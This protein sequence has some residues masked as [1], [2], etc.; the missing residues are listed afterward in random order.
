MNRP[1]VVCESLAEGGGFEP[2]VRV[3]AHGSLANCWFQPLTHPSLGPCGLPDQ[4]FS[5]N[6]VQRYEVFFVPANFL[7]VFF[8]IFFEGGVS[9]G[10]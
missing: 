2:P 5:S 10:G 7:G 8:E 1:L 4:T 9:G 6:A 3:N